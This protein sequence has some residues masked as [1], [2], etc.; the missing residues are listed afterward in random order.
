MFWGVHARTHAQ[1]DTNRVSLTAESVEG[2]ALTLERVDD[3]HGGDGLALGVFGVGDGVA[4]HVLK[5]DLEHAASLL[6]DETRDTLH[7][8]TAS[9]TADGR[10]GD[11]LDV[12]TQNLAM[13]L[14]AP[15]SES[16][17]SLAASR[18]DYSISVVERKKPSCSFE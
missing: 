4:D 17:T 1:L 16:F 7:S 8:T 5:E 14:R 13:T 18:H 10:L 2:T 12:I 15:L 9:E 6:V 3:V 11:T